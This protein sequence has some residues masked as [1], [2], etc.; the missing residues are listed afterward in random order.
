VPQA[1]F[2][3]PTGIS[4]KSHAAIKDVVRRHKLEAHEVSEASKRAHANG[5]KLNAY[6]RVIV[7]ACI[8]GDLLLYEN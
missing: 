4:P 5:C 2:D 6:G 7:V 3:G 8:S 1:S